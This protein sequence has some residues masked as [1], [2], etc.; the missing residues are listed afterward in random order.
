MPLAGKFGAT[1]VTETFASVFELLAMLCM[2]ECVS[3]ASIS[4]LGL[5][6]FSTRG[7]AQLTGRSEVTDVFADLLELF[8]LSC[9]F[10]R[11][12][13]LFAGSRVHPAGD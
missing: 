3:N 9:A 10:L 13:S 2:H 11:A 4:S 6:G 7:S 12:F 8:T 5:S 1:D